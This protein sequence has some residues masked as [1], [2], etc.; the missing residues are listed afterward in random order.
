[1]NYVVRAFN[2]NLRIPLRETTRYWTDLTAAVDNA[3]LAYMV[4]GVTHHLTELTVG[5]WQADMEISSGEWDVASPTVVTAIYLRG[6][7]FHLPLE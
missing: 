6:V 1:M 7:P 2:L 4:L 5:V 3:N